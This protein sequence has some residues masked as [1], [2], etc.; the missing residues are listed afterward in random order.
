MGFKQV[1]LQ[2]KLLD[3]FIDLPFRLTMKGMMYAE[4]KSARIFYENN[5]AI[6][7][8]QD[9][10]EDTAGTA[11]LLLGDWGHK[12]LRQVVVE[13]APGQG[14][15]TLAQYMCQV[16]R[17]RILN[18]PDDF[19]KLPS[20]DQNSA[21]RIPF[22]VDLRDL[23]A[24]LA[25]SDPFE[26]LSP[27]PLPPEPRT[28]ES[29]LARLVRLHSGG[30]HFDVND[31]LQVSKLAPLLIALDGLDEVVEIKQ[32]SDVVAAVSKALP[33]L[34][35]NCPHLSV[36]ITSRPA[37]FANSPGFD[38]SNFPHIELLSVKRSQIFTY[39]ERWMEVRGLTNRERDEF[40]SILKE[41]MTAPHLRDLS[42]N[43][44]QLTIL[45]S[46][47]LTQ[48][49]ALPDKRTNLY[50]DY[51]DMFFSRESAKSPTVRK[52]IVLLKD[53]HRF[54]GW[55][56]HA[57]AETNR[58][59]SSG[60]ISA[61]ELRATLND[62]LVAEGHPTE[63]VEEIFG[64]MLE[65]VVMIVPRIQGTYEFEVQPLREYFAARFLYDTAS[66][67]PTGKEK[68]GTKPDRFDAAARNFYW[69][70]VVR[71]LA[72]CFSKGELLDLADRVKALIEDKLVGKTRHPIELTAMLLSDWVFEQSPKAVAQLVELLSSPDYIGRLASPLRYGG[73]NI[74]P[75]PPQSG[76][77]RIFETAF[78]L[79]EADGTPL[80]RQQTFA[81]IARAQSSTEDCDKRWL[82]SNAFK[83]DPAK[84]LQIGRYL[85]SLARVDSQVLREKLNKTA[86]TR[87]MAI[88]LVR[89]GRTECA[90]SSEHNLQL[91]YNVLFAER[92]Y[93]PRPK[94]PLAPFYLLNSAIAPTPFGFQYLPV[95][96][97]DTITSFKDAELPETEKKLI[98]KFPFV[99][100]CYDL[101][102][103]LSRSYAEAATATQQL[104][105]FEA[106]L[107][108][109]RTL[110]GSRP[111]IVA[112]LLDCALQRRIR[113]SVA[114]FDFFAQSLST[115]QRL[116][117]AKARRSDSG[118][119]LDALEKS[120]GASKSLRLL[121]IEALILLGQVNTIVQCEGILKEMLDNMSEEEWS[122]LATM[123]SLQQST[124]KRPT[125]KEEGS[126]QFAPNLDSLRFSYLL[127][128]RDSDRF[129]E[130]VFLKF[131]QTYSGSAQVYLK[132]R[133][134]Q[135]FRSALKGTLD[136]NEVLKIVS[137]G[138]AR[139]VHGTNFDHQ[140]AN[141]H[142]PIPAEICKQV[143]EN[144]QKYPMAL[145]DA[146]EGATVRAARR[147][148][149]PVSVI[150]RTE[151]WF[152]FDQ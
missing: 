69:L 10:D 115:T 88:V 12:R 119:W 36:V 127:A 22:K 104:A 125:G 124:V 91:L 140:L 30:I 137:D 122:T 74:A 120:K 118:W 84:W 56:L 130:K 21:L 46:L 51:V 82:E 47:I 110:W 152:A 45:L 70:N 139:G 60:R 58:R 143:L 24:W 106:A 89:A 126:T 100:Q 76:G 68:K 108:N 78:A 141:S 97:R 81:E 4:H 41:K 62:Y 3:L 15:S 135:A 19:E 23:A 133:Q 53:L 101:S 71:F 38:T 131:F 116:R 83:N 99:R 33:R 29:F 40:R 52:H 37:A 85:G 16:H 65:R 8:N 17:I 77:R 49:S 42:R 13:G 79:L 72:G 55:T 63:V 90:L 7:T 146:A 142:S 144:F 26:T 136:W 86:L 94:P 50:D 35:E 27:D 113:A 61:D 75:L 132:F 14:K 59:K 98:E 134:N 109:C 112:A 39:A 20:R 147:G 48:G 123:T 28:M 80:D 9:D 117:G 121:L 25:G 96:L 138:Y 151:R 102:V 149:K 95:G 148:V 87:S 18:K 129:G 73:Q 32:R 111:A 2:N 5:S 34:R 64:A 107:E 105:A 66:Y 43:P 93:I 54:L 44:M 57:T 11:S 67:S 128:L 114:A 31:L 6:L 150:A 145:R 92:G 1:E 103:E